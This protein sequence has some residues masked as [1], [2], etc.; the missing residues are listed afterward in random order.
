M[1]IIVNKTPPRKDEQQQQ[2]ELFLGLFL[3][4]LFLDLL[5]D[6]IPNSS[7]IALSSPFFP[8]LSTNSFS[9]VTFPHPECD[10]YLLG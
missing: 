8:T 4:D 1:A 10:R 6:F 5:L 3:G 7:P 9:P 2:F